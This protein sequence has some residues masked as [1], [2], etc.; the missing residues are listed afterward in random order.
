MKVEG[1]ENDSNGID[2]AEEAEVSP[3][4]LLVTNPPPDALPE[5]WIVRR[6][7]SQPGYVYYYNQITGETRW[8]LPFVGNLEGLKDTL[9]D[10]A[11]LAKKET[12]D[13]LQS[14]SKKR[15]ILKS[16]AAS[17]GTGNGTGTGAS[18][19][20][21]PS[22]SKVQQPLTDE[23]KKR[24]RDRGADRDPRER[25]HRDQAHAKKSRSSGSQPEKV[26]VLHILKKHN[27]SRR[28]ASWRMPKIT[29]SKQEAAEELTELISILD[30]SKADPQELKATFQELAKTESDCSSAKRGGDLGFFGRKQMQPNFEVASFGLAVGEMSRIVETSSGVHVLLRLG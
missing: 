14:Q 23:S 28:P 4:A 19:S 15:S 5:G 6:A 25:D 22:K 20:S 21:S 13:N 2:P 27:K 12:E 10:L 18:S 16:T 7:H 26:R 29:I 11:N 30:E 9:E 8:D 1:S 17:G 24:S 3:L